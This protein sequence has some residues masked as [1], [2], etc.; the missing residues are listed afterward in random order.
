MLTL[1]Q[2]FT[3]G[4][5]EFMPV[6]TSNDQE[7]KRPNPFADTV[8]INMANALGGV[9]DRPHSGRLEYGTGLTILCNPANT[10][11]I[12]QVSFKLFD[13][14]ED[15]FIT[16]AELATRL[17]AAFGVPDLDVSR[18]FQDISGQNSDYISYKNFKK[19]A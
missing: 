4:E 14:D 13:L 1:S 11:K 18:L 10:E 5:G 8:R 19:F 2:F 12:L 3:K 6:Y 16:E 7:K 15:G 17:R 9:C